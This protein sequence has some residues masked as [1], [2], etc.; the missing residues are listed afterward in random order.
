MQLHLASSG[1]TQIVAVVDAADAELVAPFKWS[2]WQRGS[3]RYARTTVALGDGRYAKIWLHRMILGLNK[4]EPFVDHV[5]GNGL[6]CQ[7]QN[8]RLATSSENNRNAQKRASASSR[9]KGVSWYA[10]KSKWTARIKS[11]PT[12]KN[13]GYFATEEDAANAYDAAARENYGEFARFNFPRPGEL[14]ALEGC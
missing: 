6:N 3:M 10:R 14:S 13:L 4:G 7:R 2:L 12:R 1:T 5:D 8:L 11:G 9:Y